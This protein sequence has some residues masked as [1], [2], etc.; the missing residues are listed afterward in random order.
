MSRSIP[1]TVSTG[2]P[3]LD[4]VWN[5]FAADILG[6]SHVLIVDTED[7][8]NWHAFLGHSIDMQGFRAAEFV[9]VDPLSKKAPGF[10][11][12]KQRGI[13]IRE[14]A[15]LWDVPTIQDHLL[16]KSS[17]TP[18]QSSLDVL[19]TA[20]GPNGRSLVDAFNAFPYRKGHWTV[21]AYLQNCAALK[22]HDYSFRNWL[23][24]ECLKLGIEDFPPTNFRAKSNLKSLT[25]E[26]ALRKR[27]E[28]SFYQVGPALA[29]YM[30]CDWQLALWNNGQTGVFANFKL[31]SFHEEF[32]KRFG[33]GMIP[34][35]EQG[36]ADWWLS[37]YPE[38]PPRLANECIWLGLEHKVV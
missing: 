1:S 26:M 22:D 36:F 25:V 20:G 27:L 9:G 10:I 34:P 6:R 21:R 14:L 19:N 8:L 29:A 15:E 30:I 16:K 24:S 11:P 23:K 7:E 37:L 33:S 18:L 12:L 5:T 38:L 4:L 13:G 2:C 3:E 31:D 28:Q 32:V 35:D 17:G